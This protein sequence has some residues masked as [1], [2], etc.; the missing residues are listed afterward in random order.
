M[1]GAPVPV[2]AAQT[3]PASQPPGSAATAVAPAPAAPPAPFV[4]AAPPVPAAWQKLPQPVQQRLVEHQ[5][6]FETTPNDRWFIQLLGTDSSQAR[7]IE[8]LLA[9]ADALLD[10]AQVRVYFVPMRGS[11]RMGVIF[12]DFPS[13]AAATEA[14]KTLPAELRPYQPYPRQLIKLR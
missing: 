4:Q 7:R 3:N 12:G 2:P 14:L 13:R 5:K 10:P 11:E 1:A 6:W 9:R 8:T